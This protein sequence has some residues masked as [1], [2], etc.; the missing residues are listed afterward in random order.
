MNLR[1][2]RLRNEAEA[3]TLPGAAASLLAMKGDRTS[4]PWRQ[5][6]SDQAPPFCDSLRLV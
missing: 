5:S 2:L 6:F 3:V 1:G 4:R